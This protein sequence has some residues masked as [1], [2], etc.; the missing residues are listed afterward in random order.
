MH[1]CNSCVYIRRK[2]DV[3]A[4]VHVCI[5]SRVVRIILRYLFTYVKHMCIYVNTHAFEHVYG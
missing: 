5:Y 3:Y 1:V 2:V 4:S